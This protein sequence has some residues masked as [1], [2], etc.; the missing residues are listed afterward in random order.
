MNVLLIMDDV[1]TIVITLMD[2]ITARVILDISYY[3]VTVLVK[4]IIK[5]S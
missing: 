3:L 2:L 1:P 4:V 5:Y